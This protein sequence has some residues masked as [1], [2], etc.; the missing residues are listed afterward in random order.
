MLKNLASNI[1]D[2]DGY[3]DKKFARQRS[4]KPSSRVKTATKKPP[5]LKD[6]GSTE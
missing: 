5:R 4:V 1:A 6:D 2:P 3:E